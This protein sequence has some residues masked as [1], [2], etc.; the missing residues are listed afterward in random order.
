M[1]RRWAEALGLLPKA[2]W[3]DEGFVLRAIF[4]L[5]VGQELALTPAV[6]CFDSR[7]PT[8]RNGSLQLP[9]AS[10]DE[11]NLRTR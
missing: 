8:S 3:L 2:V 11:G 10:V 7:T 6:E 4:C 5:P 9:A 1:G